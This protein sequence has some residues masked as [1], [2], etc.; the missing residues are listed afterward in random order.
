MVMFAVVP[1]IVIGV[2]I[3][4]G[5]GGVAVI[6]LAWKARRWF[7]TDPNK[8]LVIFMGPKESGKTELL[9]AL[10]GENFD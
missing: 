9:A 7:K 5:L 1:L 2:W 4:F 3:G 10:K 6:V 8:D